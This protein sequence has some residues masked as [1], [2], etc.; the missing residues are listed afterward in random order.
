MSQLGAA[1]SSHTVDEMDQYVQ[2]VL[3]YAAESDVA[4]AGVVQQEQ[5]SPEAEDAIEGSQSEAEGPVQPGFSQSSHV[6]ID[7]AQPDAPEVRLAPAPPTPHHHDP[8]VWLQDSAIQGRLVFQLFEDIAP[9][10]VDSADPPQVLL[11]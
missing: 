4:A 9:M 3:N 5:I 8:F 10:Y 1:S 6:F 11:R 2:R 7:I